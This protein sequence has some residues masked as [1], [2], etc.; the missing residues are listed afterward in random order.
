MRKRISSPGG[1]AVPTGRQPVRAIDLWYLQRWNATRRWERLDQMRVDD[2][3]FGKQRKFITAVS[4]LE[5]CEPLWFGRIAS[6][7]RSM[8]SSERK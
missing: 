7:K 5:N 8:S 1:E 6:K 4:N 3:Y 2:I